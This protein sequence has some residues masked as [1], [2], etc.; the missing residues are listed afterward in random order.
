MEIDTDLLL[1]AGGTANAGLVSAWAHTFP[2][3]LWTVVFAVAACYFVVRA[4]LLRSTPAARDRAIAHTAGCVVLLYVP[5]RCRPPDLA[6]IDRRTVHVPGMPGMYVDTTI[7]YPAVG[8]VCV[9]AIAFYCVHVVARIGAPA[10]DETPRSF[11][12]GSVEA[13]R[14]AVALVLAYAILSKLV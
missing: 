8:L 2:R 1:I 14:V 6:R 11:A 12:S 13:S 4:V 7:T 9:A 10:A 3:A 5:R